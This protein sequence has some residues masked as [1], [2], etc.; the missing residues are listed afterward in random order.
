MELETIKFIKENNNW[1]ELLQQ[2]PYCLTIKEDEHYYLL[3]YNQFESDFTNEI[4]KECRG[5]IIDKDTLEPVALSF[6]KFWEVEVKE[7]ADDIDWESAKIQQKIDGSKILVFWN[8]YDNK[9]QYAT[10]GNLNAYKTNVGDFNITFGELFEKALHNNNNLIKEQFEI[11]LLSDYCYTFELVS[12]ENRVVVPYEQADL[13]FI[14]CRDIT[15]FKEISP[16]EWEKS[17]CDYIKTPKEYPLKTLEDCIKA[18]EQ[19]N[20]NEEGYVV[21][22]KNW[23]RIKIKSPAWKM[24]SHLKGEDTLSKKRILEIIVL[25]KED[26]M[27]K[28]FPEY[29]EYFK[30]IKDKQDKFLEYVLD[31][32]NVIRDIYIDDVYIKNENRLNR[33][34]YAIIIMQKYK[35]IS[36]FLFQCLTNRDYEPNYNDE[37]IVL[38]WWDKLTTNDKIKYLNTV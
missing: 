28:I 10:S 24:A 38:D 30:E 37:Y 7:L 18:T 34:D 36:S 1:K 21:V 22:D 17:L 3:K 8:K 16:F 6:K 4:V 14:G 5:L 20:Y 12:P 26:E 35:N 27:L 23:H 9:W 29:E 25:G 19:M 13:Y 32:Y 15:T 33:K 31:A 2:A 11:L